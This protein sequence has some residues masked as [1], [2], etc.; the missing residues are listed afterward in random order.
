MGVMDFMNGV[1]RVLEFVSDPSGEKRKRDEHWERTFGHKI[2]KPWER[3]ET[4]GEQ[5]IREAR[6]KN[7]RELK[8]FE[9]RMAKEAEEARKEAERANTERLARIKEL[10]Q[11][12]EASGQKF[13]SADPDEVETLLTLTEKKIIQQC[14][15]PK[16][17]GCKLGWICPKYWVE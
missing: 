8:A 17:H 12:F 15:R 9:M 11:A 14:R 3:V 4:Y 7:E 16:C 2:G 5:R 13:N 6:E 10:K 1:N